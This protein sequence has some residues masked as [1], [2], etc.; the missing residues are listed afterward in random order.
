[1]GTD[2]SHCPSPSLFFCHPLLELIIV[3]WNQCGENIAIYLRLSDPLMGL[4]IAEFSLLAT[5]PTANIYLK[6]F[7]LIQNSIFNN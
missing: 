5:T 7:A 3:L 6:L 4:I 2:L 1:M